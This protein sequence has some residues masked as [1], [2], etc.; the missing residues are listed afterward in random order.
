MAVGSDEET[1]QLPGA[2]TLRGTIASLAMSQGGEQVVHCALLLAAAGGGGFWCT[3]AGHSDKPMGGGPQVPVGETI[4][5][6]C[7]SCNNY[8]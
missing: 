4:E 6:F 1:G 7:S 3:S 8:L 5:S 2:H